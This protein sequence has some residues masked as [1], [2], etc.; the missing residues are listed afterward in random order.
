M[1]LALLT[2]NLSF[3][4]GFVVGFESPHVWVAPSLTAEAIPCAVLQTSMAPFPSLTEGSRVL[5]ACNEA[6]TQ[7]YILGL[8]TSYE[9]A[10]TK[11]LMTQ[12]EYV[13]SPQKAVQVTGQHVQVSAQKTLSLVCGESRLTLDQHGNIEVKGVNVSSRAKRNQKIKGGTV[14]I[15]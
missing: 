11:P 1:L 2:Q 8:V 9:A 15:N 10:T 6:Q 3:V 12:T 5:F 13:G 7:G 14:E 4:E